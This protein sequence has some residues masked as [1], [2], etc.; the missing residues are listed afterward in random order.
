MDTGFDLCSL[1]LYRG[2]ILFGVT[3][4]SFAIQLFVVR[5]GIN[6]NNLDDH[7]R[8]R[9]WGCKEPHPVFERH[10]EPRLLSLESFRL[11]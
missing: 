4:F 11:R 7:L 3:L 6:T 5:L 8:R 1:L 2:I 10:A 9:C